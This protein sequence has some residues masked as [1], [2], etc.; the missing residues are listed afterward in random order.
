MRCNRENILL[1]SNSRK[2]VD[3][4]L[5]IEQQ[6]RLSGTL[7]NLKRFGKVDAEACKMLNDN[8]RR[9]IYKERDKTKLRFVKKFNWI[10]DKQR[11]YI[12][13]LRQTLAKNAKK[14]KRRNAGDTQRFRQRR[15]TR[16]MQA[17]LAEAQ[18]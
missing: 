12:V 8:E 4:D 9:A 3:F 1:P 2:N 6:I 17:V 7:I 14:K 18:K 15:R 11:C 5:L 13:G 10:R 16:K